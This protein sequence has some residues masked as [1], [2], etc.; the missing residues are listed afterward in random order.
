MIDSGQA[1]CQP[2]CDAKAERSSLD[3]SDQAWERGAA[4]VSDAKLLSVIILTRDEEANLPFALE[5][6][7]P[8]APEIFVVD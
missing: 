6:L 1:R 4:S 7:K 5:S 3:E 2:R 8:L